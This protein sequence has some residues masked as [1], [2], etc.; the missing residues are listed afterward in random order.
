MRVGS[1][2]WRERQGYTAWASKRAV[3]FFE[4]TSEQVRVKIWLKSSYP[5]LQSQS[6]KVTAFKSWISHC[7]SADFVKNEFAWLLTGLDL[8]H[9]QHCSCALLKKIDCWLTCCEYSGLYLWDARNEMLVIIVIAI[10]WWRFKNCSWDLIRKALV[11]Q[12]QSRTKRQLRLP[13]MRGW[14]KRIFLLIFK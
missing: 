8:S 12:K 3:D 4:M 7:P 14:A 9:V 6:T 11:V 10:S 13:R 5:H 2:H 1:H